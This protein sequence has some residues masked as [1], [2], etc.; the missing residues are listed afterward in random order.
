M[1][2]THKTFPSDFKKSR[3][4][5]F[6]DY[7]S[8]HVLDRKSNLMIETIQEDNVN[9]LKVVLREDKS[10]KNYKTISSLLGRIGGFF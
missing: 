6:Y 9:W 10:Y 2:Y 1:V 3:N 7:E 4:F 5:L 8:H